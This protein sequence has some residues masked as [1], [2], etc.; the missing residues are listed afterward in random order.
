M[1]L[2]A[3]LLLGFLAV[4]RLSELGLARANTRAL[5]AAG[6]WEAGAGHYPF[7]VALH[8]AWLAA[9]AIFGHDAEVSLPWLAVFIVLQGLRIWILATLGR[10]WTTRII[11]TG[12]PPVARGP[13]RWLRHPNYALV[14]LEIVAA[15]M[16]L[17]LVWVAIVFSAL[18]AVMLAIRIRAEDAA[19]APF[20][21]GAI[22]GETS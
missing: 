18:N 3:A 7:I 1:T 16:A 21:A 9:L 13:F 17:G 10:R 22:G 15:P 20:R 12:E 11:V 5:M 4:Q 19:W 2:G 14:A 6:A 8:A